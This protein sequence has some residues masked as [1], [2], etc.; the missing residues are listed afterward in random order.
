MSTE[1]PFGTLNEAGR[2][3]TLVI[4][5]KS[6]DAHPSNRYGV[7]IGRLYNPTKKSHCC[8]GFLCMAAGLTQDQLM[9]GIDNVPTISTLPNG[10]DRIELLRKVGR[11]PG[12]DPFVQAYHLNDNEKLSYEAKKAA[13]ALFFK[14]NFR[15]EVT[16]KDE[17][18][19]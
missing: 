16:Y 6:W 19:P 17:V 4:W 15:I 5:E 14:E 8:V 3:A 7:A 9:S 10:E 11:T 12:V 18:K 1:N 2:I 13:I